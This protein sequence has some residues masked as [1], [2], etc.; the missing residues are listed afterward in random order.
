MVRNDLNRYR[1]IDG[2]ARG[3]IGDHAER[4]SRSPFAVGQ[5]LWDLVRPIRWVA[6]LGDDARPG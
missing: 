6:G 2:Y 5:A 4:Y 3:K 1:P